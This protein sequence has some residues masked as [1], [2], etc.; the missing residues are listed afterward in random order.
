MKNLLLSFFLLLSISISA[1]ST[2]NIKGLVTDT[3]NNSLI[4]STVILMEKTDST[5]VEFTRTELDG[6]FVFK[7]IPVGNYLVKTTYIG[8]I[9]LTIDASSSGKDVDL[10]NLKMT[11]IASE[12]MEVV[13]KAAKAP[14]KMRG[15]TIEYDAS[16]FQVPAGSSVEELLKR[17]PGIEIAQDGTIQAD[18]KSVDQ[19]TVDGKKFFGSDP[20]AATKNL[21]AEG[22]SKVQVFDTKTEE[23]KITGSTSDSQSKTMNLQ[24]KD[25]F[26]NGS[27]GRITGGVGTDSRAELKGN[28]NRFNEKIQF[29]VVGVGNNTGRNGLSWDDYQDFMGSN[30]FN[31]SSDGDFGFGGSNRYFIFGGNGGNSIESSIQSVF[32]GGNNSGGFP[33]NYNGGIN[34]NYDHKKTKLSTIYYYNQAQLKRNTLSTR[35]NFLPSSTILNQSSIEDTDFSGGHRA[36]L[37]LEQEIDS[38][39][40]LKISVVGAY[41]DQQNSN[42]SDIRL[43]TDNILKSTSNF[44]NLTNSSGY[45]FNGTA[46]FRKKFKKSG[47]S[48]GSNLSYLT[49]ALDDLENQNSTSTFFEPQST[50]SISLIKRINTDN[51]DKKLLKANAIYVEPLSKVFFSQTFYNFSNRIETGDRTVDDIE[52]NNNI[53]NEFLSRDYENTIQLHRLGSSLRYSNKGMNVSVGLAYQQYNLLGNYKGKGNSS[54]FGNVDKKFV[55]WIPNFNFNYSPARNFYIDLGYSIN[56]DEPGIENLQPIVNNIN[57]LFIF[58]GNPNLTPQ[59]SHSISGR[60]N[61]YLPI[62]QVRMNVNL[63]YNFNTNNIINNETVDE[64]LVTYTQPINYEGGDRIS[65]YSNLS[66]P[67]VKGKLKS[68]VNFRSNIGNSFAFVNNFLNKT[69]SYGYYPGASLTFTPNKSISLYLDA[70]WNYVDTKYEINTSQNQTTVNNSYRASL[71]AKLFLGIFINTVFNYD[72]YSNERFGFQQS[73]PIWNSSIYKQFLPGNKLEVRLSLYDAFNRNQNVRQFASGNSVF[74]SRTPSLA[75]Y[76]MISLSYNIKGLKT[77][78]DQGNNWW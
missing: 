58:E 72:I 11:E 19:V 35:Q 67:I 63:S 31:F 77:E 44:E 56:A 71:D 36:E 64:N 5:M 52:G 55:N 70:D 66:F 61:R 8:Y 47:R 12:L 51:Q 17:L 37:T 18:G 7:K 74:E 68:S 41:I 39:H 38:F 14:I 76:G 15:D 73:I 28:L 57:P 43:S 13:I 62:S 54:I 45:L 9:P 10:G 21:P 22:I 30:S 32:F 16:T 60:V 50:D 42:I 34:F 27:F 23:E 4:A 20:K 24:L 29:S 33:E 26:K 6:S 3:V 53:L 78:L 48:F 69:T 2:F 59:I 46:F 1:Q 25:E 40:S 49:T 75:R 65:L